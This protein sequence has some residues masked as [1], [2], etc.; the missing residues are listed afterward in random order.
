MS[1]S[2]IVIQTNNLSK[3]FPGV[4][5]LSDFSFSLDKG[6]IHCLV[7]ENGAGK[8]TFIKLLT[9]ALHPD[10]GEIVVDGKSFRALTPHTAQNLGIQVIYQEILLVR[11]MSVAENVFVG[12]EKR[13][14][15]GWI[16]HKAMVAETQKIIDSLS[17]HL[18]PEELVENLSTADQ[19]FVKIVKALAL[20]PKV[21]I[22]DEPT[23]MF[24]SKD[25]E[26]VLKLVQDIAGRGISVIY[27]SHN[28]KEV[29]QIANRITILRDGQFVNSHDTREEEV[30]L[31]I[32]T[33][34]MVGRPVDIFYERERCDI[35]DVILE[36]EDL[37]LTKAS[38][39][40]SFQL[41]QGEILGIAGM[42]GAGR[43]E[44]VRALFGADRKAGGTLRYHGNRVNP[45]TP[46]EA[47]KLGIGLI[48]EDRQKTGLV[49]SMD[50]IGNI[51]LV[52][53]SKFGKFWLKLQREAG[54][55][56]TF[57]EKLNVKTPSLDQEVQFLSGG[58]QQKVVIAKWLYKDIDVLIF[59]EP[60]RGI[61]VNS[62]AEIYK[63][64]SQ[65]VKSG[66]SIIMIS[67]DLI[68]LIAMSDRVLVVR[69]GAITSE[70][71]GDQITEE[72]IIANAI[73]VK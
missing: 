17:I 61:D 51:S 28:L 20:N 49:L 37:K 66:K 58:N 13:N 43:T 7:G 48:T 5:A 4:R 11:Q 73:E 68:E 39:S 42:V 41:R 35:G 25:A 19:Q 3:S 30:D 45:K 6:Q 16:D 8:S 36:V 15:L 44:I 31:D 18:N 26:I 65:L 55:V 27:I 2:E 50:V 59:D 14:K 69:N 54:A 71:Q 57:V 1:H 64:M 22:M 40:V 60:T 34:E 24:N 70:I 21:L 9:G 72:N 56:R 29:A 52:G 53:L 62:K 38:P 10:S 12:C 46:A 33:K 47:I 32:I 63:L 67:S 23:T